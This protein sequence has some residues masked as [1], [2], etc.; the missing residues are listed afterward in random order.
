MS[1]SRLTEQ[2]T[3]GGGV[4]VTNLDKLDTWKNFDNVYLIANRP[5]HTAVYM[6]CLALGIKGVLF[7]AVIHCCK[8]VSR[9]HS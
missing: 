8:K 2:I 7:D 6:H 3:A 5:S 4:V 9:R 1:K